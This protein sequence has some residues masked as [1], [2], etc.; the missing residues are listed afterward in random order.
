MTEQTTSTSTPLG[1][2]GFLEVLG[3]E[4]LEVSPDRIVASWPVYPSR[5]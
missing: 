4:F 3:L 5:R 1:H 2:D